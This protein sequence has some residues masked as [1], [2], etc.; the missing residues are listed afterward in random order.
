MIVVT[1]E[2]MKYLEAEADKN[3]NSYEMLMEKAGKQLYSKIM[4]Y[5]PKKVVFL[6]GN[7]NN[8]GDCFV[9][10]RYLEAQNISYIVSLVCGNPK[11]DISM[12]NYNRLTNPYTIKN[13]DEII[14]ILQ[15][16]KDCLVVDGIFGTGFHGELPNEIR[17]IFNAC[18]GIKMLAVD[19]PS[20]GNCKTGA[21]SQGMPKAYETI[22]FGYEKFGMTQYPLKSYCGKI[23]VADIDIPERYCD[24][25]E[26]IIKNIDAKTVKQIIPEKNPASHKGNYGRLLTICGSETMPGACIMAVEAALKSGV[27]IVQAA[28]PK[29]LMPVIAMRTPEAMLYSLETDENGFITSENLNNLLKL[30][31]K[32]TA[33][34]SGCG[35]GVTDETQKLVKDLICNL[36]TKI[37][38][39]ADGINCIAN[40]IDII[41]Q[42]LSDIIVTPHPAE[43]GRLCSKTTAQVQ[44]DR[45]QAAL[46]LSKKYSNLTLVL[47]G[48]GTVT[49]HAER[50]YVNHTG[51]A[52][53][54]KGGSG[55]VLA[56][57]T[58]SLTAQG[59]DTLSASAA[60]VFVHGLAGD[61]AA[62]KFSM[63]SMTATDIIKNLP[64]V[65]K[66][67][68]E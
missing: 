45:L 3:G 31:E 67:I 10:A 33:V 41:K 23:T 34:L 65:F 11:T 29:S 57:I 42:S 56:G 49:V 27:G 54:A 32:S 61:K 63:Q 5:S 39:D 46:E 68:T 12:L 30:A 28:V 1:P 58:A 51:N 17:K 18:N 60:A 43:M 25:F 47:K 9:A 40:S 19:V 13:P 36:Q 66:E 53:M 22:T 62:V 52:G 20:G 48:A 14:G 8:G 26:Y 7:G 24:K 38:L 50:L 44:S 55:D 35:L 4:E 2:Q 15:N 21:V 6:C 16:I 59:I 64:D 37:I